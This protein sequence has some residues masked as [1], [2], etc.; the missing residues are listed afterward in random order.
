MGAVRQFQLSTPRKK[1]DI[2][3]APTVQLADPVFN[4]PLYTVERHGDS[5]VAMVYKVEMR[6]G[7]SEVLKDDV[8][9]GEC[10]GA[11]KA[12]E[13]LGGST[14]FMF[15]NPDRDLDTQWTQV[16]KQSRF[17]RI[18]DFVVRIPDPVGK[19]AEL[20]WKHTKDVGGL[21]QRL[22]TLNMKLVDESSGDI[23]AR[24]V[25]KPSIWVMEGVFEM[26]EDLGEEWDLQVFLSCLAVL[27]YNGLF[28]NLNVL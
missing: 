28:F 2:G 8:A 24:F 13:A 3:R 4:Q 19:P 17:T 1:R 5:E 10:V 9:K 20:H 14:Q 23:V 7:Q 15:G 21:L 22:D 25:H 16:T 6:D 18:N 11:V 27:K 26:H 12:A